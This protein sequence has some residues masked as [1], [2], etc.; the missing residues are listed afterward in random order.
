MEIWL[1]QNNNQERLLLPVNPETIE[2]SAD[3]KNTIVDVFNLG[4]LNLIGKKGLDQ[5]SIESHFPCEWRRYCQYSAFP[6]PYEC[7]ELIKKWWRTTRPISL[8]ITNTSINHA[9]AIESF[10]YRQ[11]PGPADVYYTLDLKEYVFTDSSSI[12]GMVPERMHLITCEGNRG[13]K[14]VPW[15]YKVQEGDTLNSIALKTTGNS[16]NV[17]VIQSKNGLSDPTSIFPGMELLISG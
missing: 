13:G 5:I 2:M 17:T 12:N 16:G 7:V 11:N 6:S 3:G 15:I 8:I 10:T 4:E 14:M 9:M 1:S